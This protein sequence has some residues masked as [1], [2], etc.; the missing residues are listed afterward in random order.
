[1]S[2][3]SQGVNTLSLKTLLC[4]LSLLALSP[5]VLAEPSVLSIKQSVKPKSSDRYIRAVHQE[6]ETHNIGLEKIRY[7]IL[8]GMLNTKGFAWV[9]DGE[10]EGYILARFDYRG[11]T[12]VMRIEYDESMVQLKYQDALGDYQCANL[13]DGICYKNGRGYYNYIKNL[14]ASI[15]RQLQMR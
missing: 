9:Y 15:A 5:L 6:I 7:A 4:G 2:F 12:N 3:L 1:M 11:D 13:I 8:M 14:R 10:G